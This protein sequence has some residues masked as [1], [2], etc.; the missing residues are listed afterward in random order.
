MTGFLLCLSL[1]MDLGIVNVAIL[2][3]GVNRGFLPSFMI[4]VGSSFGDLTYAVL[5]VMGLRPK[6]FSKRII[7]N[8]RPGNGTKMPYR[9]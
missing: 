1:C 4:G 8:Q 9:V 2:R 7:R 6:I 3:A 5:S